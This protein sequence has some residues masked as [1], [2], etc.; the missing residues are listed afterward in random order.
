MHAELGVGAR[1]MALHRALAEKQRSRD[2]WSALP[3]HGQGDDLAFPPAQRLRSGRVPPGARPDGRA[4]K[5]SLDRV[6][7][8]I[9]VT[10]PGPVVHA[11]S[12]D[13]LRAV[14]VR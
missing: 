9:G 3:G 6:E 8:L 7:D 1:E 13:K 14:N 10:Q 5:E 4:G 2:G 11:G 12:L